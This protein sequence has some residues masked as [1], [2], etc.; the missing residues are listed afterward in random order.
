KTSARSLDPKGIVVVP[1]V[2]WVDGWKRDF[3]QIATSTK[4]VR[5]QAVRHLLRIL[6][7]FWGMVLADGLP[8]KDFLDLRLRVAGGAQHLHQLSLRVLVVEL[9]VTNKIDDGSVSVPS[10]GE[11]AR[12]HD[13]APDAAVVGFKPTALTLLPDHPG[14]A[15]DA[16]FFDLGDTALQPLSTTSGDTDLNGIPVHRLI[17]GVRGDEDVVLSWSGDEGEAPRMHRDLAHPGVWL[18]GA[19]LFRVPFYALEQS[20]SPSRQDGEATFALQFVQKSDQTTIFLWLQ[21]E[22]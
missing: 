7:G 18:F 12:Q 4:T 3:P 6:Q 20:D 16:A 21:G 15:D 14:E 5:W 8:Q 13:G 11:I 19:A 1:G 10:L 17:Q 22:P 9:W 2:F